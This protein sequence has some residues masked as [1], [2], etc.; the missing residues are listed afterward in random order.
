MANYISLYHNLECHTA[1]KHELLAVACPGCRD[2]RLLDLSN[3]TKTTAFS[4][5][6]YKPDLM[7]LGEK[8]TMLVYSLK[9]KYPVLELNCTKS[10]FTG[11]NGTLQT[12]MNQWC[13]GMCYLPSPHRTVVLSMASDSVIRAVSVDHDEF[14][15]KINGE[16]DGAMCNPWGM[17][18]SNKHDAL[19]ICDGD[20]ERV[21]V[22]D[23][24][25]GSHLQ[26]V[27]LPHRT[28]PVYDVNLHDDQVVLL[29][30]TQLSFFTIKQ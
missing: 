8:G 20:N 12:G 1:G 28:G 26:T 9:D 23:P 2:I 16:I 15:W 3:G 17:V 22:L 13:N 6:Q 27:P 30:R 5:K 7:C 24:R 18:Y 14:V 29:H 11:P 21:L 4:N 19:L 25:D 10:G